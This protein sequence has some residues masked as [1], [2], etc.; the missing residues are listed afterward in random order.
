[1]AAKTEK[2][3][4]SF[5]KG[6]V[7]EA[8]P[9][10]FPE[11]ASVDE[12]NF[13]L[14]RDGSRSRR[15][16]VD[17]ENLHQLNATGL[18]A[19]AI[20]EGR[21][22][23]HKWES[24]AGDTTVSLGVVRVVNKLWFMNLLTD[25]PSANLKNSGNPITIAGL[26]NAKIET[27]VINNK[28]LIVSSDIN[29]PILL[30]YNSTTGAVTQ[31]TIDIK[32]RDIYGVD[33]GYDL[34]YRP[35]GWT[36]TG[37]GSQIAITNQHKYNLRNQG[38]NTSIQFYNDGTIYG[39]T[40]SNVLD[41]CARQTGFLA[42]PSN[43][44]QWTLGKNSN[45]SNANYEKFNAKVLKNNSTSKYQYSRGSIIID[46][47]NRGASRVAETDV[48]TLPT[49]QE[50]G[51]VT[52]VASYAQRIFYS[53]ITSSVTGA[54]ARSPN[55]SG[56]IFFT[57]TIQSNDDLG[58]C[59]Q[60]ADPTDPA[61]NDLIDSDGGSI[62]IPEATRIIKI[63]AS[64]ASL[65]V[66]CENGIW[67]VYGDTG[68]FIATSFQVSKISTN[69]VLN[70][71]SVVNVNGNFFYWSKAGIYVLTPEGAGG[72]FKSQSVSLT[73][74]QTL[75][76]ELEDVTKNNCKGYYDEKE[77]RVRW[78]Y[79]DTLGYSNTNFINKYNKELILDLTLEAWSVLKISDL[80]LN[81]PFVADYVEIPGY[82]ITSTTAGVEADGEDVYVNTDQVI[83]DD[84][85]LT[86]RS[87]LFSFLTMQ[88][89]NFTVSKY[90]S[91]TFKDWYS[92]DET[93]VDYTSFLVTGYELFKDMMR[94]KQVP[95][96]FVYCK[97]TE[98]GFDGSDDDN[99]VAQ[100]ESSCLVQAQWNWANH[101]NS[102]KWGR[103]F[104]AY[105]HLRFYIPSGENDDFDNGEQVIVTKNKLRGSGKTLSLKFTSESGKDMKLLGWALPATTVTTV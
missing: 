24:P 103:Q 16:G 102:G 6:L 95:Y 1:M 10:T 47:F 26:S 19:T 31:T 88:G 50:T 63:A 13:V 48:A 23:F 83:V 18:T 55:Y 77:N 100:N 61:I 60:E 33:D 73:S 84:V 37:T 79:N 27:T 57:K 70:A 43:S 68:G 40:P 22:S 49:D 65:I 36:G 92:V 87:S 80:D 45:P 59:Y 35:P 7:T 54:D 91:T 97:K 41:H 2:V 78:L 82:A 15:L 34:D 9:L 25:N 44:D 3:F 11:N 69:G 51:S 94:E 81:T 21:Q 4:N 75:F 98:D 56:Y 30:T 29:D 74:I 105:R 32:I 20:K 14:N 104:Q 72:R 52:T 71:D 89:S 62:Q 8:S 53:G 28:L 99:F 66:F 76:L 96:L 93:G 17:F 101:A 58:K 39:G 46:A 42:Y 86:N 38:W 64:Q 12:E 90:Q 67:E 5:V 85:L